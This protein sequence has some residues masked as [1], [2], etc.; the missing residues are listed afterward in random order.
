MLSQFEIDP[1][2]QRPVEGYSAFIS[3]LNEER[4]LEILQTQRDVLFQAQKFERYV[5]I[6]MG[7]ASTI[8]NLFNSIGRCNDKTFIILDYIDENAITKCFPRDCLEKTM[9]IVLSASGVTAETNLLTQWCL[10]YFTTAGLS[11]A[12]HSIIFTGNQN[13]SLVQYARNHNLV[14]YQYDS[15]VCGRCTFFS[16]HTI[17]IASLM[18]VEILSFLMGMK[19]MKQQKVQFLSEV[20]KPI[21]VYMAYNQ[22][23]NFFLQ[24]QRQ[25]LAESLG[26]NGRGITPVVGLAPQDHHTMLQLYLD[27]PSDKAFTLLRIKE[28]P[29]TVPNSLQ[30]LQRQMFE[31]AIALLQQCGHP[32]C[33]REI[34]RFDAFNLG[35]LVMQSIVEMLQCA[36]IMDVSPWTQPAVQ[37]MKQHLHKVISDMPVS[38][39]DGV[40]SD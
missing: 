6:G 17:F 35:H 40:G 31:E 22:S 38:S 37:Q 14:Y 8:S 33:I 13:S 21:I 39:R 26:K 3:S 29:Y 2:W 28:C 30:L 24:W 20:K 4:I 18:N 32:F 15:I 16:E 10:S 36:N 27:G 34:E 7:A 11:F 19:S 12:E 9:V 23:F 1:M 25:L 5:I